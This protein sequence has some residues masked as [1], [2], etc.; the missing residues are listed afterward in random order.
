MRNFES[1]PWLEEP[2]LIEIKASKVGG[3][4]AVVLNEFILKI[5]ISRPKEVAAPAARPTAAA[6]TAQ[7]S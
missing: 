4:D 7:K 3:K 1:S 6:S 2:A 5:K